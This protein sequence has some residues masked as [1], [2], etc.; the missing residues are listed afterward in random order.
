MVANGQAAAKLSRL[1]L[2][3]NVNIQVPGT[4]HSTWREDGNNDVAYSF[5]LNRNNESVTGSA[6]FQHTGVPYMLDPWTGK[7]SPALHYTSDTHS[8]SIPI[9]LKPGQTV[10][11][12]FAG[13]SRHDSDLPSCHVA[14]LTSKVL[15]IT[16]TGQ[17]VTDSQHSSIYLM[18]PWH[19][20]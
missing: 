8:T 15:D 4:V 7:K 13:E 14:S 11:F 19:I 5:L 9:N 2:R 10:L 12:A 16:W 3:A 17:I 20:V 1:E 6:I 18:D